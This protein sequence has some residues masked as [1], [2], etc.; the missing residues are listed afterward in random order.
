MSSADYPIYLENYKRV[1]AY[2]A[3]AAF[4][5]IAFGIYL[6][7][8]VKRISYVNS[9]MSCVRARTQPCLRLPSSLLFCFQA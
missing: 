8:R 6:F 3:C 1:T 2:I 7:L 9:S 4:I 5:G